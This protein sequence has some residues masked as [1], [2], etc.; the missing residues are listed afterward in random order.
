MTTVRISPCALSGDIEVPPSKSLLHRGLVCA[1]LAG[2]LSRC[3]LPPEDALSDDIRTTLACLRNILAAEADTEPLGLFCG[4]S[5]TTL[6]LLVPVLAALGIEA[7]IDGAGR[8]PSRPMAEYQAAFAGHETTLEF[9]GDGTFLPLLLRGRLTP[10]RF[11]IPGNVSSQY[12]SGL[13]LALPLL[14]GDSEIVLASPLESEPYVDMTLDVMRHFGVGATRTAEG[15]HVPGRQ[16]YHAAEDYVPE[17]DFSQAAFW[18]L[19]AFLGHGV[20]VANLPAR[21]SQGDSAFAGMLERLADDGGGAPRVFDVA[22]TPDL[23]PALAAAAAAARGETRLVNAARLRLKESDRLV[24]TEAMLRA[25][26]VAAEALPDGLVVHGGGGRFRGGAVNGCRDHRIVMAAAMLA[27]RA[28]G[29]TTI[30][31]GDA[32]A[33]SYP[34]FFEDFRNAG[35]IAH[36]FD[37]G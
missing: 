33:K 30:V 11:V 5:G 9:P 25:F 20:A 13:L 34:T 14:D 12:V 35:G 6:R 8:L 32:V 29:E 26:G 7:A 18:Q 31:G 28:E 4:E 27:T 2:D 10:G 23:V 3:V 16:P 21:T 1:A 24:A 17:P 37:V 15:Y 36:E 19:A 22:Q